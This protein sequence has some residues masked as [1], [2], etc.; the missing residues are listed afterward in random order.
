M[1]KC[2]DSSEGQC[3]TQGKTGAQVTTKP[4]KELKNVNLRGQKDSQADPQHQV[5][6]TEPEDRVQ[7][8]KATAGCVPSKKDKNFGQCNYFK[9]S[10]SICVS[11]KVTGNS[12]S[13]WVESGIP[14]FYTQ[15]QTQSNP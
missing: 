9:K 11:R 13:V 8:Q 7:Y 3:R 14:G 12:Y 1:L 15:V 5:R 10:L 2:C 4:S 6:R